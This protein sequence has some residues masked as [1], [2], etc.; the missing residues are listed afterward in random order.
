MIEFLLGILGLA[1][2]IFIIVIAILTWINTNKLV[3][4]QGFENLGHD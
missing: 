1:F 4:H 2:S 3:Y